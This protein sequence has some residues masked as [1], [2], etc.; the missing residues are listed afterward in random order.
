MMLVEKDLHPHCRYAF[1]TLKNRE[2]VKMI[3]KCRKL[4]PHTLIKTH[5]AQTGLINVV[6]M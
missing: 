6:S 2:T 1:S 4:N 5:W 3:Q